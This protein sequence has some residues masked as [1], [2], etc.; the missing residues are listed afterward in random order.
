MSLLTTNDNLVSGGWDTSGATLYPCRGYFMGDIRVG[1]SIPSSN[2]CWVPYGGAEHKL[3][4]N[5][6]ILAN[7]KNV[8]INWQKRP[9]DGSTPSNA[10]PGGRMATRDTLYIGRYTKV[11]NGLTTTLIGT[12]YNKF[13]YVSYGGS[14]L[15]WVTKRKFRSFITIARADCGRV[16]VT[17]KQIKILLT[18][19]F[20]MAEMV[21]ANLIMSFPSI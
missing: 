6:E 7:P 15:K 2:A 20:P 11:F 21:A 12:V 16:A 1:K 8:N 4:A 19:S 17:T 18:I 3:K 10:I 9:A 13:C 5:F 14:Q